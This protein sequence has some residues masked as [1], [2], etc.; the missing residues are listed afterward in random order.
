MRHIRQLAGEA[1]FAAMTAIGANAYP[2][3]KIITE[4]DR[5][6]FQQRLIAADQDPSVDFYGLFE[7]QRLLGS[8]RLHDFNMN[9]FGA[10]MKAGG[11]GFVAVDLLHKKQAVA[12][13]LLAF[14]VR[15]CRDRGQHLALLYPFRP[16]FYK[17]MGF[18]YGTKISQYRTLPASL[19]H[20]P[21]R[22]H[23]RS[24]SQSDAPLA[25][26]CYSR[27]QAS[28]H[29]MIE[30]SER[31]AQLAFGNP[32]NKIV[33]YQNGAQ[34]EGYLVFNFKGNR[35]DTSFRNDIVIRE[36]VYEH[37]EALAGLL[38]FLHSQA[39]QIDHILFNI[40][41]DSFHHL[42][43]DPRN[44]SGNPIANLYEESNT[45]GVGLM[46]R[47]VN[48][49]A[50]FESMDGHDFGGQT[51]K[52]KIAIH[53]SFLPENGGDLVIHFRN[54]RAAVQDDDAYDLAIQLDIAELSSL[55]MGVVSF[56]SLQR[57]SLAAISDTSRL[58]M[59]NR[60]F[61]AE[62]KPICMTWF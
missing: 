21:G 26:A 46:Y 11:V 23:V 47:A 35:N 24:L 31:D 57:Y 6:K 3:L 5:R 33:G 28:R 56:K 19:P 49:R 41:D 17:K 51:C 8:M 4:E 61:M 30:R 48:A 14:F 58:D 7:D 20:G 60:L 25:T 10:R 1:D 12:K 40:Q 16:D 39:D 62:E 50:L 45:Q 22:A 36:L 55:L 37:A 59:V 27:F 44:G 54:G 15:R 43:F 9:M 13:D 53:D 2:G 18:G 38:A 52:L 42:L 29:G 32:E 34:I